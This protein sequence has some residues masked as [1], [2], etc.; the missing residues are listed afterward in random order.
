MQ[1]GRQPQR[2][3]AAPIARH[4]GPRPVGRQRDRLRQVL[5]RLR[6]ERK[7]A[8]NGAV[9]DRS[10]RPAPRAARACSRHIAPA[11]AARRSRRP[12]PSRPGAPHRPRRDRAPTVP[13]TS[14]RRRCDAAAAAA[15]ARVPAARARLC[16]SMRTDAPAAAA[17]A[18]DRSPARR[19]CA[20]PR[21]RSSRVDL[22][23][24]QPRP[25]RRRHPAPAG[26]ARRAVSGNTVRRLS[27]RAIRSPSASF[28][29]RDVEVARKPHRQRDRVGRARTFQPVEEPQPALR[30]RQRHLGGRR[31][32]ARSGA[33]TFCPSSPSRR[34]SISTVGASNRLRIAI[35]TSSAA[36]M[37]PISRVASSEWPPSSKKLSSMPTAVEPQ[38]LGKQPAQHLLLRRARQPPHRR[39]RRL[40]GRQRAPVELAVRRQRQPI[41]HHKRRRHHVVRQA[42]A[43]DARAALQHPAPPCRP[44]PPHRPRDAAT[45]AA[46]PALVLARATTAAC[47]TPACRNSAASISPGSMRK[48]RSFTCASA[49]PKNSST[50]SWRQRA[51]SPVRYIRLPARPERVG[52]EPLRRQP[53]TSQ[54]PAR[55]TRSRDIQLARHPGR[56]RLQAAVQNIDLRVPDRAADRRDASPA[57]AVR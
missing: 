42:R 43:Q 50:P 2:H 35:S 27:C 20:A 4:L 21:Q 14:R 12:A 48:P 55:Q 52:H 45:A 32:I 17:R 13:A 39:H 38:R 19:R 46:A 6:P 37:R 24:P 57:A 10:P 28:Q 51:R 30:K 40:R 53:R 9:A 11:A 36:R 49:R 29:R 7:L 23:H 15:R 56:H 25:R 18:T 16:G 8:R 34:T 26:A 44:P 22:L 47:A 3:P 41:E 31:G 5:E 54:I 33:R 1:L